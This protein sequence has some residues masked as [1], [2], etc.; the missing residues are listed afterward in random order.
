MGTSKSGGTG[1]EITDEER[2]QL[3]ALI[4]LLEVVRHTP[5]DEP[6][7]ELLP[8]ICQSLTNIYLSLYGWY[9]ARGAPGRS[10]HE[11]VTPAIFHR[12]L[13]DQTQPE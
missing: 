5:R 13:R 10:D 2:E 1:W 7:A 3:D 12:W 6:L 8:I 4:V 11:M 9:V